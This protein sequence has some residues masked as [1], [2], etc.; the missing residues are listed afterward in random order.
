MS[1]SEFKYVT[2]GA[3]HFA[4]TYNPR[5]R[6]F[7]PRAD[8]RYEVPLA[9]LRA[10]G[11]LAPGKRGLDVGCGDGVMLYKILRAGGQVL[12]VDLSL[13]GLRI[14]RA[15]IER[16]SGKP[17]ALTRASATVLPFASGSVDFVTSIEVIEH[18][19]DAGGHLAE[20]RRVLR[21]GGVLVVT[22]PHRLASGELQDPYHVVEYDAA[23]L[24]ELLGRHFPSAEVRGMY[25]AFLDRIYYR[26]SGLAP[27]DKV[28]RGG[29]KVISRWVV[30]PYV[31]MLK[32][33]PRTGWK[34]LVAT[35]SFA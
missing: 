3:Y 19:A 28:V 20:I 27:L 10:H 25:P 16:R 32:A 14:A 31:H 6:R 18:L 24:A 11:A 26:A 29:F 7:D 12:G 23:S 5:L 30:N 33:R 9:L 1:S 21:P 2:D 15:E 17:P 34:N 4:T 35:A 22:T 13:A 8:A